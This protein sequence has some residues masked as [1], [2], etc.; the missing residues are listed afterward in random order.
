MAQEEYFADEEAPRNYSKEIEAILSKNL[1]LDRPFLLAFDDKRIT[2]NTEYEYR[3]TMPPQAREKC[4]D[5]RTDREQAAE[6]IK[7]SLRAGWSYS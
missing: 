1:S 3:T 4:V 2:F 7:A 5:I 6:I